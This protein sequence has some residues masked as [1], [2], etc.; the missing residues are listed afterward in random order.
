M[1]SPDIHP[2]AFAALRDHY[3]ADPDVMFV[4]GDHMFRLFRESLGLP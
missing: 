2:T 1:N 4:R 3:S